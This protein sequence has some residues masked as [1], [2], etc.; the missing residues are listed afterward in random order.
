MSV[1]ELMVGT[2]PAWPDV[3]KSILLRVPSG[4]ATAGDPGQQQAP[5]EGTHY[6][7]ETR[8]GKCIQVHSK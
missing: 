1:V 7:N 6:C 3:A 4:H 2:A 8:R 5:P